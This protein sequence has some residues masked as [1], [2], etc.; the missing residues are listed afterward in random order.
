MVSGDNISQPG[1]SF[2]MELFHVKNT[3]LGLK[4]CMLHFSDP[5]P[6]SKRGLYVAFI[7]MF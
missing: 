6:F 4:I 2:W 7:L 3:S 1:E 5:F